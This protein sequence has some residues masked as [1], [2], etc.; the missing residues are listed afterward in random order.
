MLYASFLCDVNHIII[1]SLR[2]NLSNLLTN[3][4]LSVHLFIFRRNESKIKWAEYFLSRTSVILLSITQMYW[5]ITGRLFVPF[6][7]VCWRLRTQVW[8]IFTSVSFKYI[9][10]QSSKGRNHAQLKILG[11]YA[12][13]LSIGHDICLLEFV[14][15]AKI[16]I[17]N[18]VLRV[19]VENEIINKTFTVKATHLRSQKHKILQLSNIM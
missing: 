1:V 12:M 15:L 2:L 16:N 11:N 6:Q 4:R 14:L 17:N 8:G 5:N 18:L 10:I 7:I 19:F 9:H 3:N 13:S